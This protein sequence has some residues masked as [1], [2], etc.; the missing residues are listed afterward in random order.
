[1]PKRAPEKYKKESS[2]KNNSMMTVY[3]TSTGGFSANPSVFVP[4]SPLAIQRT[5][6]HQPTFAANQSGLLLRPRLDSVALL[7]AAFAAP[8]PKSCLVVVVKINF[9]VDPIAHL[10]KL[11]LA[12]ST[13]AASFEVYDRGAVLPP[14]REAYHFAI[15]HTRRV[16]T[17][18]WEVVEDLFGRDECG[19]GEED[20]RIGGGIVREE[21]DE[22]RGVLSE[23]GAE[24]EIDLGE[25]G[26]PAVAS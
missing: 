6:L 2:E 8:L 17:P 11:N 26:N 24:G 12:S 20:L 22:G 10:S 3:N 16:R 23:D 15:L 5:I 14:T 18:G 19:M 25:T 7:D 1:V 13:P 9:A 21:D 4:I